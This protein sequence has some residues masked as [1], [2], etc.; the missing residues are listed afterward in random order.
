MKELPIELQDFE[1]LRREN[2]LYKIKERLSASME[3]L[4]CI[5][6]LLSRS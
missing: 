2:M 5:H 4:F 6:A 3:K 1:T